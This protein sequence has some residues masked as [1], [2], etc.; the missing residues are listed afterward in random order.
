MKKIILT[1]ADGCLVNW[2]EGFD[3]FMASKGHPRVPNTD[4]EYSISDRHN[5]THVQAMEFVKEFNEGPAIS[6]LKPFAD[7]VKYVKKLASAGF[8]FIVVTS[9]SNHPDAAINRARNLKEIFGDVFDDIHCIEQGASKANILMNWAGT[10]YFWIE[11]HMRQAEAGHEAGLK[12]ILINHPYNSHYKTD[13]FPTVSFETPW[14]EIFEKVCVEYN[15][16]IHLY[17]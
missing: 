13:L 5:V 12:T 8:R 1:D 17:E 3:A 10:G 7:S 4:H 11:D 15:L 16:Y 9:I 14:K 6:H 2:N